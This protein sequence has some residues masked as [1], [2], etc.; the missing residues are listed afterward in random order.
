VIMVPG[1]EMR[2]V[3]HGEGVFWSTDNGKK[4]SPIN[5][6]LPRVKTVAG[7]KVGTYIERLAVGETYLFAATS[8]GIV[9][10]LPLADLAGAKR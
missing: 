2:S 4:W 6:G 7:E 1:G 10:R 9:W 5:W 8:E 3:A